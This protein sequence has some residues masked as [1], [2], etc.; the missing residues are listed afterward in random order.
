MPQYPGPFPLV[1]VMFVVSDADDVIPTRRVMAL[2]TLIHSRVFLVSEL[3]GNHREVLHVV[4]GR[5]LMTLNT[6]CGSGRRMLIALH[7]PSLKRVALRTVAPEVLE[8]RISAIM[9]TRAVEGF[10]SGVF[11]ELI[12]VL[13][14][15]P[16]LQGRQCCGTV[17]VSLGCNLERAGSDTGE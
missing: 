7:R 8:V 2:K 1:S 16:S 12:G 10:T 11:R 4:T 5:R 6:L 13:N 3:L 14:L 9:A 17:G 15:E